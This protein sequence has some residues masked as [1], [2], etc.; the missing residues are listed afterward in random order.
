MN[1]FLYFCEDDDSERVQAI[2]DTRVKL[3]HK[4]RIAVSVAE[5]E[6]GDT[7]VFI[8]QPLQMK[9][10]SGRIALATSVGAKI[11]NYSLESQEERYVHK[12]TVY[13]AF[14]P[15]KS[16][17]EFYGTWLPKLDKFVCSWAPRN[18]KRGNLGTIFLICGT[19]GVGKTCSVMS[20]LPTS[21][22]KSRPLSIYRMHPSDFDARTK[23]SDPLL[24][25]SVDS[26][27]SN[28]YYAAIS[29]VQRIKSLEQPANALF[30]AFFDDLEDVTQ[31]SA[32]KSYLNCF[33][34]ITALAA[35]HPRN[36]A[37]VAACDDWWTT[38]PLVR[39]L[40]VDAETH[41]FAVELCKIT[42][43]SAL[44]IADCLGK[45][46][47]NLSDEKKKRLADVFGEGDYLV[48]LK[49]IGWSA[50]GNF[51][52]A[53]HIVEYGSASSDTFR[54]S[55]PCLHVQHLVQTVAVTPGRNGKKSF[56]DIF[57]CID[58]LCDVP[59]GAE[60]IFS[61]VVGLVPRQ[62]YSN[63]PR[64]TNPDYGMC[65]DNDLD[66]LYDIAEVNEMLALADRYE[67]SQRNNHYSGR[68]GVDIDKQ[69][70][71]VLG[72]TC[73]VMLLGLASR[74]G[75]S[76]SGKLDF[77]GT[78]ARESR[79]SMLKNVDT[80]AKLQLA[81]DVINMVGNRRGQSLLAMEADLKSTKISRFGSGPMMDMI[82]YLLEL[83]KQGY[84]WLRRY[85][86]VSNQAI[87]LILF[88]QQYSG[89]K[90]AVELVKRECLQEEKKLNKSSEETRVVTP[91]TK[92]TKAK[93]R[94]HKHTVEVATNA[95]MTDYFQKTAQPID[96]RVK[97]TKT[98]K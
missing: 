49:R 91:V 83:A 14:D 29:H 52:R 15:P 81:T 78:T 27:L 21:I 95:K 45:R 23:G 33:K 38:S 31:Q 25:T 4:C 59:F 37:I 6:R 54:H 98:A 47:N 9:Q 88:A 73:P 46:Y 97:R 56:D 51:R 94:K 2:V 19:G 43:P 92:A 93:I 75:D 76:A 84:L 82:E 77:T 36:I 39:S 53:F 8:A 62:Y 50:G 44:E 86:L 80:I 64:P 7:C 68:D 5:A 40:R 3:G 72:V 28:C 48:A 60:T 41:L 58:A 87:M 1:S 90:K 55:A 69:F 42:T 18:T 20:V 67:M 26:T 63:R 11:E 66:A 61:N 10:S 17:Q 65:R 12:Q 57:P 70:L 32:V 96:T 34:R 24:L 13:S 74:D 16:A 85:G 22:G 30:I 35:K 71:T 79:E 89:E